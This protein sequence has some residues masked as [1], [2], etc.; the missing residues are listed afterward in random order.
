VLPAPVAAVV[1]IAVDRLT[2]WLAE[3]RLYYGFGDILDYVAGPV[4]RVGAAGI[5]VRER[6]N[7][8][9]RSE[10]SLEPAPTEP[11]VGMATLALPLAIVGYV[12]F[13]LVFDY[14]RP[15]AF[16]VAALGLLVAGITGWVVRGRAKK[17]GPAEQNPHPGTSATPPRT[18]G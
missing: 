4:I 6:R 2:S 17:S 10:S 8:R 12:A 1:L 11:Y 13:G 14:N 5:I 9:I 18:S 15:F 7:T 3:P 16:V